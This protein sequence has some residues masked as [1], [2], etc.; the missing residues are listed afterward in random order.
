MEAP[1][2]E[3]PQPGLHGGDGN[4]SLTIVGE[5]VVLLG[6][7]PEVFVLGSGRFGQDRGNDLI[8]FD[9]DSF[10]GVF[11]HEGYLLEGFLK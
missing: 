11:F 3:G 4:F 1:P 10:S 2:S 9:G 8:A 6:L 7:F 5:F